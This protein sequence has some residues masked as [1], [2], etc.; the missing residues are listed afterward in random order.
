MATRSDNPTTPAPGPNAA[1]MTDIASLCHRARLLM[2]KG[3]PETFASD[4]AGI[5]ETIAARV[6]MLAV[7]QESERLIPPI[8]D[9]LHGLAGDVRQRGKDAPMERY[10][11]EDLYDI[12]NGVATAPPY[13]SSSKEIMVYLCITSLAFVAAE[14]G[15]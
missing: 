14:V 8:I 10:E 3:P 11:V 15:A 5:L 12:F 6:Q 9:W 4:F 13:I 1:C 7:P 2:T